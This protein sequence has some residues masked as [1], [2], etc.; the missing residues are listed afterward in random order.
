[1][2][3]YYCYNCCGQDPGYY[4]YNYCCHQTGRI[5]RKR[6]ASLSLP[7]PPSLQKLCVSVT[8]GSDYD[9]RISHWVGEYYFYGFSNSIIILQGGI[10]LWK[11]VKTERLH[12][13][14]HGGSLCLWLCDHFTDPPPLFLVIHVLVCLLR[15]K[16]RCTHPT[17][18]IYFCMGPTIFFI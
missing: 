7:F 15:H 14:K 8:G 3:T 18:H 17:L 1:M 4:C 2:H 16:S 10:V 9:V 13:E 6:V 5:I 12:D 11:A